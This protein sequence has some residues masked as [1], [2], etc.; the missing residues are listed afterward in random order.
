[1]EPLLG[2]PLLVAACET[3]NSRQH[4]KRLLRL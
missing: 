2:V 4:W 1:M 3:R